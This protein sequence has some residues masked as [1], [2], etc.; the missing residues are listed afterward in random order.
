MRRLLK[1]FINKLIQPFGLKFIRN[2]EYEY[3]SNKYSSLI[4]EVE[5][6][7][8]E[9]V[10]TN[11]KKKENRTDLI[12]KLY[13]T[14]VSEA[15]YLAYYLNKSLKLN[16]DICEFGVANGSTS[17][18]LANEIRNSEKILWLF[19]SF[20]GLSKPTEKDI[21]INDIFNLGKMDKYHGAMAYPITEVKFR[22][23][24]IK[25]SLSRVKIIKGFIEKTILNRKLPNHVCFAYIDFD[26]YEPVLTA[27]TFLNKHLSKGGYIVVD[28]YNFFSKGVKIAVDEF[29]KNNGKNY[30]IFLPYKFAGHFCILQKKLS[31]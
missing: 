19:D 17:A 27:L 9:L 5:I 30:S 11:F 18:F 20:Q 25:F 8:T 24:D 6:F 22:L 13:G 4:E 2:Y 12:K 1:E 16:G 3:I 31:D 28:D 14:N 29:M 10:F 23:K 21:L 7:F 15:F 26:L